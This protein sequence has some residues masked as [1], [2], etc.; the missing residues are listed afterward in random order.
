MKV[1]GTAGNITEACD[2]LPDLLPDVIL[3]DVDLDSVS[4]IDHMEEIS[5]CS[6]NSKIIVLTAVVD[7]VSNNLAAERGAMGVVLKSDAAATLIMA[8]R[9]VKNG[10][11][12]YDR[13]F[14]AKVIENMS[15]RNTAERAAYDV[16]AR[17]TPREH[18]IA[19]KIG[20]GLVNKDIAKEL[21][22]SEKTVRNCLT[23]IYEKLEVTNR[24]EL[25]LLLV[26]HNRVP[27]AAAV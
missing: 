11:V 20:Q 22:I 17:L 12:W 3:L 16:L 8:I 9:K 26:K 14:T 10:E 27:P 23:T 1:V 7:E 13:T 21:G 15:R 5:E 6:P 18:Q 19:M 24:L 4:S 2:I 25:A